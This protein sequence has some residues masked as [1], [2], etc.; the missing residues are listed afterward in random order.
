MN[1]H[2]NLERFVSEQKGEEITIEEANKEENARSAMMDASVNQPYRQSVE[3]DGEIEKLDKIENTE[4][5]KTN[6]PRRS[7]RLQGLA[8]IAEEPEV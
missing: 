5:G 1:F 6:G 2:D 7:R 3:V 4:P 8:P